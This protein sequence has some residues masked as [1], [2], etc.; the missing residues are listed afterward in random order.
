MDKKIMADSKVNTN[1]RGLVIAGFMI[2]I[3]G[4]GGFAVWA[5]VAPLNSAAIALG[6]LVVESNRKAVQHLEGGIIQ[7]IFVKEGEP[8]KAGQLLVHLEDMAAR[9]RLQMLDSRYVATLARY[10]RLHAERLGEETISFAPELL[11]RS[12]E[13]MVFEAMDLQQ[14]HLRFRLQAMINQKAIV[15][16]QIL[17]IDD[18]IEGLEALIAAGQTRRGLIEEEIRSLRVLVRKGLAKKSKLSVLE[19]EAALINGQ[20]G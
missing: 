11:E 19:R 17:Q 14:D 7:D 15:A 5:A 2:I 16:R 1:I 4:F 12:Q 8:V 10:N 13:A 6:G 3:V 9:T 18:E 20:I